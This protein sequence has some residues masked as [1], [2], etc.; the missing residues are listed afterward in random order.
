MAIGQES[1]LLNIIRSFN[2]YIQTKLIAEPPSPL[3]HI[4]FNEPET[5]PPSGTTKW[6]EINWIYVMGGVN[7][8]ARVQINAVSYVENDRYGNLVA[9]LVD[10]VMGALNINTIPLYDFTDPSSLIDL[11][12][13]LLIPRFVEAAELPKVEK[14]LIRGM[15]M[16]YEIY[17]SRGSILP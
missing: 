15:R 2:K 14:S 3:C 11:V 1:R 10:S 8:D 5:K 16:D 4:N 6:L 9:T 13:Y 7:T 17:M 12:P